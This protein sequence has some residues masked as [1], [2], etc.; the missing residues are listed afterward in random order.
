MYPRTVLW[1]CFRHLLTVGVYT[2]VF[3][4]LEKTSNGLLTV[5]KQFRNCVG[6]LLD[7]GN[8]FFGLKHLSKIKTT[9]WLQ[10]GV[11]GN[12]T[13]LPTALKHEGFSTKRVVLDDHFSTE[14]FQA[15]TQ[16]IKE[17]LFCRSRRSEICKS[18]DKLY[19]TDYSIW[20]IWRS[21]N[22]SNRNEHFE[23]V[24]STELLESFSKMIFGHIVNPFWLDIPILAM[25]LYT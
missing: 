17:R 13:W 14:C 4:Y 5:Q 1:Y 20:G 2:V 24:A 16:Y 12:D 3:R 19:R 7:D 18:C 23:V 9:N 15:Y 6:V 22:S 21:E 10:A 8:S 11:V 25:Q